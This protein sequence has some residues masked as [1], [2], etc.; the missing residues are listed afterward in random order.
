M[1]IVNV[2]E[3]RWQRQLEATAS[4]AERCNFIRLCLRQIGGRFPLAIILTCADVTAYCEL[5]PYISVFCTF[6]ESFYSLCIAWPQTRRNSTSLPV[7]TFSSKISSRAGTKGILS[8]LLNSYFLKKFKDVI[9]EVAYIEKCLLI[10]I[11]YLSKCATT[12]TSIF[13]GWGL[14]AL[15]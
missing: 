5:I 13:Y 14:Y 4:S 15:R 11:Q 3:D 6:T 1:C 8:V 12:I 7:V 9:H 2:A 10:F